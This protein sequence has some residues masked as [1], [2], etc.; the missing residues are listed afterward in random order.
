M[1]IVT[2]IENVSG[3]P[4]KSFF[5]S[6]LTRDID[7]ED[8][9]LDLLDNCVDGA[10]RHR[11]KKMADDDSLKD[12]WAKITFDETK[13]MIEDNC[14]GIPWTLAHE[15]AFRLGKPEGSNNKPG[16]IGVVGIGMKRAIFKLGRQSSVYSHHK[17]DTFTVTIPPEW[18]EDDTNWRFT[19]ERTKPKRKEYGTIVEIGDLTEAAQKAF[20]AGSTFREN[21]PVVVAETYSYLLQKGFEV[22]INNKAIKRKPVKLCFEDQKN[23]QKKAALIRPFVY[24][25]TSHGI[26]IFVTVGYRSRILTEAE[27]DDEAKASF[28]AK[29]AG[30]TVVCNDRVVLANDRSSKTGWGWGG[31]PQFHNQFSCIAGIVEFSSP[32]MGNLPITTTKR[33]IDTGNELYTL[34]R[35]KM[36]EGLKHFTT[37]TNRWKGFESEL[38]RHFDGT[39]F[40]DLLEIK[41][42]A[43]KLPMVTLR[44]NGFQQQYKPKLPEKKKD[45]NTGR[46][47]FVKEL[48]DI[49]TVSQYL[50]DETRSTQEIGATCFD[51]VL[52]EATE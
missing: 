7:L 25:A 11:S 13:F 48:E 4:A 49:E 26:D 17:D 42:V 36:Q 50:F 12:Y 8:A 16:T 5:V 40:L 38:R 32:D 21:F 52:K 3:Y 14:G 31:I 45:D 18:F 47:C 30:W 51:R 27:R 2:K 44:S 20:R 33:G 35:Q 43:E 22:Q 37:N 29:E 1:A 15:Y 46:I 41:K 28:A 34:V 10:I 23:L 24:Q 6:M 9:I 39:A 19:A